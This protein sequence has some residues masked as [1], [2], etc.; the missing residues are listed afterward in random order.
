[1]CYRQESRYRRLKI[2]LFPIKV[3]V[4]LQLNNLDLLPKINWD[5]TMQES[6]EG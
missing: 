1:M 5:S 6:L 2:L 3:N 4:H